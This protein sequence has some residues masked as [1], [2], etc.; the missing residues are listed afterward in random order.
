MSW[1]DWDLAG[2]NADMVEFVKKAIAF[3]KAYSILEGRRFFQGGGP[4]GTEA[5]DIVWYDPQ[6]KPVKWADKQVQTICYLIDG[7]REPSAQG[8]YSLFFALNAGGKAQ[9]VCLPQ[10]PGRKWRRIIDTSSESPHDF[11]DPEQAAP[12]SAALRYQVNPYTVVVML[13]K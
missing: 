8:K 4:T 13:G 10:I 7:A 12:C 5:P 1:F 2:K 3:R 9:A 11:L 6:L